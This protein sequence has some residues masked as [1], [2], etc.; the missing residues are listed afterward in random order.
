M[1]YLLVFNVYLMSFLVMAQDSTT[2]VVPWYDG[3]SS[4]L[5]EWNVSIG[6]LFSGPVVLGLAGVLELAFRLIESPKPL[7]VVHGVVGILKGVER[8][9]GV[10]IAGLDKVIPQRVK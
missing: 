5:G 1:K 10:V 9:L 7:S 8:L 4:K 2:T 6:D 3:V